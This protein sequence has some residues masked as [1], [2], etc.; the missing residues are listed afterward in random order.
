MMTPSPKPT[1]SLP[2]AEK[3]KERDEQLARAYDVVNLSRD[4]RAIERDF[5]AVEEGIEE[6]WDEPTPRRGL[7]LP[8]RRGRL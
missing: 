4:I 2:L 5:D 8:V 7:S 6:P 3:L 1:R